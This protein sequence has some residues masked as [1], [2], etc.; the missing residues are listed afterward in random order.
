MEVTFHLLSIF[1]EAQINTSLQ[2][3]AQPEVEEI[4]WIIVY[5][6]DSKFML[7]LSFLPL[8][9]SPLPGKISGINGYLNLAPN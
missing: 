4:V 6:Q 8:S 2:L 1:R 3:Q 7:D 9:A 5:R